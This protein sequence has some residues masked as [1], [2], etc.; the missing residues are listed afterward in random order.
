MIIPKEREKNMNRYDEKLLHARILEIVNNTTPWDLY[1]HMGNIRSC[2]FNAEYEYISFYHRQVVPYVRKKIG[3]NVSAT[4]VK[5]ALA[6]L[7]KENYFE[8]NLDKSPEV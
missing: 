5:L 1:L 2:H 3:F 4:D 7:K 6:P 8:K